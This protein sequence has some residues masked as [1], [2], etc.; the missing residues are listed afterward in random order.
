[1]WSTIVDNLVSAPR[2]AGP[3]VYATHQGLA[4]VPG[5]GPHFHLWLTLDG[6][7]IVGA[8]YNTYGC[9]AAI[10]SGE[11]L[12]LLLVGRSIEQAQQLTPALLTRAMQGLPEGKEHCPQLA[13]SALHVALSTKGK[14]GNCP[15]GESKYATR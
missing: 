4:G 10:A 7:Q 1:M 8:A 2:F 3:L 11:M 14:D 12:C 5:E 9:L 15:N 13:I 6:E